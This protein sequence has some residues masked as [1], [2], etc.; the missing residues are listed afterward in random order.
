MVGLKH[1]LCLVHIKEIE[2]LTDGVCG[3]GQNDKNDTL[4]DNAGDMSHMSLTTSTL[5]VEKKS[6]RLQCTSKMTTCGQLVW[7]DLWNY[8]KMAREDIHPIV[9]QI[10]AHWGCVNTARDNWNSSMDVTKGR[11]EVGRSWDAMLG[12]F[13]QLVATKCD[14]Y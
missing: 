1:T 10:D 5:V 3:Q 12:R 11:E 8:P 4:F 13:D 7:T 9:V 6:L 14:R 2:E